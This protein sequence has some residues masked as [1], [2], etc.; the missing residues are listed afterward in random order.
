MHHLSAAWRLPLVTLRSRWN[1]KVYRP[2]ITAARPAA[3]WGRA[4]A[5]ADVD[6]PTDEVAINVDGCS[7]A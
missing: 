2:C 3:G 1:W 7:L 4:T 6:H 5:Q